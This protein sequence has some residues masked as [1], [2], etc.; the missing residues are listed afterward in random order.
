MSAGIEDWKGRNKSK[1]KSR[2]EKAGN[3]TPK[4]HIL[5]TRGGEE[6]TPIRGEEF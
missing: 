1:K 6:K 2:L 3:P 5:R 4:R